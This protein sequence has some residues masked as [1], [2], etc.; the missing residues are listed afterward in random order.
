MHKASGGCKAVLSIVYG[1]AHRKWIELL[2]K[3]ILL[4]HVW[5]KHI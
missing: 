5:G 1:K 2:L 4:G 3:K